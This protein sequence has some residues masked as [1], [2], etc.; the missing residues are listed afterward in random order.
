M[1]AFH[2]MGSS[3]PDVVIF[4]SHCPHSLQTLAELSENDGCCNLTARKGG[5]YFRFAYLL[6]FSHYDSHN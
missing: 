1:N 3:A 4:K 5:C 2:S 6:G